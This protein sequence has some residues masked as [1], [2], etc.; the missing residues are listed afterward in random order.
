L[1][2][3]PLF[4]IGAARSGTNLVRALLSAHPAIE[5]QNEPELILSLTRAGVGPDDVVPRDDRV[6]LLFDLSRTGLT[7]EHIAALAPDAI[8]DFLTTGRDIT[9]KDVYEL[10][11][12]RPGQEV[13]WG[14][15]SLGNAYLMREIAA[16]YPD[17]V[18]VHVLRDPRA[19]TWSWVALQYLE[20][21]GDELPIE[22]GA[23]GA[24]TYSALRWA[25][26]TDA[27]DA[28]AAELPDTRLARV[29]FE[30]L[31]E[32]PAAV[33]GRLCPQLGVEFDEQML[34]PERRSRDPVLDE[35]RDAHPK[36]P[37]PVDPTRAGRG[38][39]LPPWAVAIVERY[40]RKGM[41]RH[42]YAAAGADLDGAEQ[43]DLGRELDLVEPIMRERLAR[44]LG[45]GGSTG[46]RR[47][48]RGDS[49]AALAATAIRRRGIGGESATEV[50]ALRAFAAAAVDQLEEARASAVRARRRLRKRRKKSSRR[51]EDAEL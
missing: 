6:R 4:V 7:R 48:A 14:E 10:L 45:M 24:V 11:L 20:D 12:P 15:K 13:V 42:G 34:D 38:D 39:R 29:R 46:A 3:H 50:E 33:L 5:L 31:V 35:R 17:A 25:S 32:D 19:A 37:M 16:L 47:R 49:L 9:F 43:E 8:E 23:I 51:P 36:L 21:E 22:Q 44:E 28:S 2:A 27:I 1:A 18:F 41:S 26:W 30:E 40:A